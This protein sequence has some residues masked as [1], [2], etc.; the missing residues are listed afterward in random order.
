[1]K[2]CIQ[3]IRHISFNHSFFIQERHPILKLTMRISTSSLT[4]D[5]SFYVKSFSN[6]QSNTAIYCREFLPIQ[7]KIF[8]RFHDR[9][10]AATSAP[11]NSVIPRI[12]SIHNIKTFKL[13]RSP[14]L[15][16]HQLQLLPKVILWTL[17]CKT[18]L[19]K[20]RCES[21][22]LQSLFEPYQISCNQCHLKT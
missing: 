5:W 1:V 18:I 10:F 7:V 4:I 17:R 19:S 9:N 2:Y 11:Q 14:L 8:L 22:N 15:I 16:Q 3:G 21:D 12:R 13:D 20:T 6:I